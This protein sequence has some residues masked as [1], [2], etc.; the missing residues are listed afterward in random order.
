MMNKRISLFS[1]TESCHLRCFLLVFLIFLNGCSDD[2]TSPLGDSTSPGSVTDLT[3]SSTTSNSITLTWTT[4]GDDGMSGKA[5]QFDLRH[6]I[7]PIYLWNWDLA[8]PSDGEP[9]PGDAGGVE[10]FTLSDLTFAPIYY[11]AVRTGDEV[12]NWSDLSNV[13]SGRLDLS[14]GAIFAW[15]LNSWSQ[16]DVPAPNED[17][18]A[19]AGGTAHSLGLKSD[20]TIV[21]WG[22]NLSGQ[23]NVPTPNEDFVAVSVGGSYSAGLKSDGT[24]AAWGS[25]QYNTCDIPASNTDFVTVACGIFHCLGLKSDGTIVAWGN[26]NYSQCIVPTPNTDFVAIAAGRYHSIGLKSD[27]TITAWGDNAHGQCNLPSPN[28]DFV[29]VAAGVSHTLGLK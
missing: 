9:Q 8:M 1:R 18:V 27:G 16:C 6:S 29:D 14:T 28:G 20:G 13:V 12:P 3:V 11:F 15:G 26:D 10:T 7:L 2:T 23:C 5:S 19:V 22:Y 21:A 25:N 4:P 17:F 24:I